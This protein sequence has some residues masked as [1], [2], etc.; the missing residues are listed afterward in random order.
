[1]TINFVQA[2]IWLSV[3]EGF[4]TVQGIKELGDIHARIE[5]WLIS[6]MQLKYEKTS[7]V[8]NVHPGSCALFQNW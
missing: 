7:Q 4:P 5:I 1:M 8:L 3:D 6:L 2:A